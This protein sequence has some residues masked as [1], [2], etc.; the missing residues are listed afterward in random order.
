[1]PSA[2]W[3]SQAL[4]PPPAPIS[5]RTWRESHPPP[6]WHPCLS[7]PNTDKSL[8]P[9]FLGFKQESPRLAGLCASHIWSPEVQIHAG[10]ILL[11]AVNDQPSPAVSAPYSTCQQSPCLKT[12]LGSSAQVRHR[13]RSHR[14]CLGEKMLPVVSPLG[15]P[16][17]S[18]LYLWI[19]LLPALPLQGQ[20]V[21]WNLPRAPRQRPSISSLLLATC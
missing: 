21:L 3:G 15:F 14:C 12:M 8:S 9:L 20:C 5:S 2:S 7:E 1:M 19:P 6:P 18:R 11:Q 16:S 13:P 10:T 17:V 4:F